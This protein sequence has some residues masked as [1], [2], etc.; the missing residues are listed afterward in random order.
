MNRLSFLILFLF[1]TISNVYTQQSNPESDFR[2]ELINNGRS[3]VINKYLGVI[4]II[5]IPE[6]IQGLPV[7]QISSKAFANMRI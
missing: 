3:I 2:F 6:Q 7:T 5:K 1:F 4:R